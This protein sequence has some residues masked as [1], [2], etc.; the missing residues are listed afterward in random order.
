M[1]RISKFRTMVIA[2][3][4][5]ISAIIGLA[6][7]G[8]AHGIEQERDR[9]TNGESAWI[10]CLPGNGVDH[11]RYAFACF[12]PYGDVL[13]ITYTGPGTSVGTYVQWTNQLR[14]SAGQWVNYRTGECYIGSGSSFSI[15]RCNKDFYENSTV[16]TGTSTV[17]AGQGS[18]ISI[19]SS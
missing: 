15:G 14:N 6:L 10:G 16:R 8:P 4:A 18:R 5:A 17:P 1:G 12:E 9:A 7:A 2:G 11:S 13:W 19:K 3:F